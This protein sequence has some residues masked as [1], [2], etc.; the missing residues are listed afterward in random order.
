[1]PDPREGAPEPLDPDLGTP[2]EQLN[3]RATGVEG[4]ILVVISVGGVIGA[5]GRYAA[6]EW[7]PTRP[8]AFPWTTFGINVVGSTLLAVVIVV[9]AELWADKPWLRPFLGPGILGGFTTFSTFALDNRRLLSNGHAGVAFT[10]I[11]GTLVVCAAATW[12]GGA[13]ARAAFTRRSR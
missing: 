2:A 7:W 11:A 12:L 8:G 1:M 4:R 10:Y 3:P 6:G 13:A 5:V 9:A